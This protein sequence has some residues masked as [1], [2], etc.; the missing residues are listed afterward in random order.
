MAA[1]DRTA[2]WL[3]TAP[4]VLVL[5]VLFVWP[6]AGVIATSFRT[7]GPVLEFYARAVASPVYRQVFVN[8]L[9]ISALVT[10]GTLIVS[11]PLAFVMA[12][13]S[14]TAARILAFV[15]LLPFWTSALVRTAAWIVLLQRNGILNGILQS[16]GLTEAPVAFLYNLA[17]VLIGMIHVLMPFMVLPLYAAFRTIDARLIHAAEG[18]GASRA[19]VLRR[20]ILP[21]SAPGVAAGALI[22][23]M[24]AIGYYITPSLMGG[25]KQTMI[26]QMISYH[27]LEQ[28]DWGM[29]SALS[30]ILLVATLAIFALFQRRF[31]FDR[32]WSGDAGG[33]PGGASIG[34]PAM[35][36]TVRLLAVLAATF[37]VAP[38]LIVFPMSVSASPFLRFPPA[39]WTLRWYENLIANP[40][41]GLA[42]LASLRVATIAV[43][44]ALALGTAA[45][46]GISRLAG[47]W[48]PAIEALVLAP[49]IVPPIIL[50]I[51]LYYAYAPLRLLG[52]PEGLALGH[53]LLAVPFVFVT[54]RAA[55]TGF[56]RNLELAALG[57]GAS[58]LT[59]FR[60]VMLPAI[61]PGLLAGAVFAFIT[62]FDELV[63]AIFLTDVHSRTLPRTIYEGIKHET[64]PT[65]VAVAALLVLISLGALLASLAAG[66]R[67]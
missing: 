15:V 22:V 46:I 30:L 64:D 62:S 36:W 32:L 10:I 51:A 3:A 12:T 48:K 67:R 43:A 63:L 19:A 42:L 59:M 13:V 24:S 17:G 33:G 55:V 7:D 27:M 18:L 25:P 29:A 16:S 54:V 26:A 53:A 38:I 2:A 31:G 35:R 8:T 23:F 47:R 6:I 14:P 11:Y 5:L 56:D 4:L 44:L 39:E 41:W 34:G 37:L 1:R 20:I 45:A 60:R 40:K 65:I 58:W 61:R 9:V 50:A 52:T 49:L 57:L 21:L 28:L 66:R